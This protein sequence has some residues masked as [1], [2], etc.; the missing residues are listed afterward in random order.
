MKKRTS[1]QRRRGGVRARPRV[2]TRPRGPVGSAARSRLRWF[3]R[4]TVLAV[5]ATGLLLLLLGDSGDALA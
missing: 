2:R 1:Q 5:A 4:A 3:R